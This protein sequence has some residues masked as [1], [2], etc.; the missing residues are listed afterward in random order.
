MHWPQSDGKLFKAK[1]WK[2]HLWLKSCSLSQWHHW[3]HVT[4]YGWWHQSIPTRSHFFIGFIHP[5]WCKIFPSTVWLTAVTAV[6]PK[7]LRMNL[8]SRQSPWTPVN[9]SI[10]EKNV[11]KWS[12]ICRASCEITPSLLASASRKVEAIADWTCVHICWD[13]NILWLHHVGRSFFWAKPRSAVACPS[14]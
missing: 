4:S 12:T 5:K 2:V 10:E 1:G 6:Y 11:E 9:V 13:M 3:S 8:P 7:G 14:T